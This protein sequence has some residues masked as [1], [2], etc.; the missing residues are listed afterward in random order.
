MA[1]LVVIVMGPP[2]AGKGTQSELLAR[3]LKGIHLSSGQLLRQRRDT[4]LAATMAAGE[5]VDSTEI[6]AIM[7]EVMS[8][9]SA[10]QPIILDG[11]TRMVS[12]AEWLTDHLKSIGRAA[13]TV[14]YLKID[15]AESL[16]RNLKRGRPDDR[17][18]VQVE[19][20]REYD[21]VTLPVLD[22]YRQLGLLHEVDGEGSVETVAERVTAVLG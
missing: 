9:V 14:I 10:G 17:P 21:R 11:F 4:K 18:E 19:R 12:E 6:E 15:R 13:A 20:W 3:R 8:K 2:G 7:T 1:A 5:L 22:Y 16:A